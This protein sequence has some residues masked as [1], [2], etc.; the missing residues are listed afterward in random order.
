VT[1]AFH[2]SDASLLENMFPDRRSVFMGVATALMHAMPLLAGQLAPPSYL[3][4]CVTYTVCLVLTVKPPVL[5]L[6]H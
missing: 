2:S 1:A 6:V 3:A 4:I 5:T